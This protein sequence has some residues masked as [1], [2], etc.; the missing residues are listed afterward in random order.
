M[1]GEWVAIDIAIETKPEFIKLLARTG[2]PRE[3]VLYRL[4]KMWG[5]FS[6]NSSDGTL[7]ATPEIMAIACGADADWFRA[8]EAVGWLRFDA[9]TETVALTGWESRFGKAAKARLLNARRQQTYRAQETDENAENSRGN[10]PVTHDRY[11]TVTHDRYATVTGRNGAATPYRGDRGDTG[12]EIEEGEDT[13]EPS[14]S[15]P[16]AARRKPRQDAQ[17][18]AWGQLLAAWSAGSGQPWN[19]RRAPQEALERLAEPGWLAAA[20]AAIPKLATARYFS[21][22]VGLPQFCGDGFV[23][24]LSSDQYARPKRSRAA[25]R[26]GDDERA[27]PR[28]FQG[29]DALA[30]ARAMEREKAALAKRIREVAS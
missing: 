27:P 7:D 3:I 23:D 10:A 21:E 2:Q 24:R 29:E 25:S 22:P 12:E 30:F 17:G 16:K 13:A 9:E 8:V 1:A 28:E 14:S 26:Q 5:W 4:W 18:A 11:A 15:P 6:L 20:I 19:G